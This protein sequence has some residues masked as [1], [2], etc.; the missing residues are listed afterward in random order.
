MPALPEKQDNFNP[1]IRISHTG[2]ELSTDAGIILIKELMVEIGFSQLV[3]QL[4]TF[5]DQQHC[6][7]H[8]NTKLLNLVILQL[9]AGYEADLA[10]KNLRND[11]IFKLLL[12]HC[13][14][15]HNLHYSI[16]SNDS[17]IRPWIE[18]NI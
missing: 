11:P 7:H 8:S 6:Y 1:K 12:G 15:H 14:W 4:V 13:N 16:S 2:G 10:A 18:V 17:M 9:I 5:D 3:A